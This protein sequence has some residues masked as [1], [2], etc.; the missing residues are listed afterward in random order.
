MWVLVSSWRQKLEGRD[1][2]N[3][4]ASTTPI[5]M[6]LCVKLVMDLID[7]ELE[8]C[9]LSRPCR[10]CKTSTFPN[11]SSSYV[12]CNYIWFECFTC[13]C[14]C[15]VHV[16]MLHVKKKRGDN[17]AANQGWQI[18]DYFLFGE[19]IIDYNLKENNRLLLGGQF[20]LPRALEAWQA[21]S[22]DPYGAPPHSAGL[23][24]HS[25]ALFRPSPKIMSGAS[26]VYFPPKGK[27]LVL[28]AHFYGHK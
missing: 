16:H 5:E 23:S 25:S 20:G 3:F 4:S 26:H 12:T 28:K 24:W 17:P 2:P 19:I 8:Y 27:V 22:S 18:I 21:L 10:S 14:T 11:F 13:T 6:K 7:T 9:D 15:N 1:R